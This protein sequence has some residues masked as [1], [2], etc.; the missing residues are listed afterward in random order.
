MYEVSAEIYYKKFN[1]VIDFRDHANLLL[2]QYL[3]GEL[4]IGKGESYGIETLIRKNEG[5]LNGWL[6][7]TYSR[8]FRTIPAINNGNK[9]PAPYDKPHT[10]NL[11]LN[12]EIS[13]KLIVSATWVYATGIP[14][15]FPTGRAFIG[16]VVIPIYSDRNAYRMPDYHRL[17]LSITLET[18]QRKNKRWQGEWNFSVYNAYNRHNAWSINFTQDHLNPYVTYA[19]KS[20]LFSVIPAITYNF[21]F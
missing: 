2:N 1:D 21:K 9:Y 4:R 3:E 12:Y 18:K 17:D 8:S 19:E 14:V 15:T 13:K 20:Y 5:K 6:S 7:Y 16:N 10:V 11:V